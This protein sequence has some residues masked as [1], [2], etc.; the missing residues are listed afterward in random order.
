[1]ALDSAELR[2][3]LV[4]LFRE[5]SAALYPDVVKSVVVTQ[6]P[7]EDGQM[8]FEVTEIRGPLEINEAAIEPLAKAIAD[9]VVEHLLLNGEVVDTAAGQTW[10]IT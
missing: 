7:K 2:T 9:A 3:K 8:R 6:V 4:S 5:Y 1:M 10:R